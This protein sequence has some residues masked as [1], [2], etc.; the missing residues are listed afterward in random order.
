MAV[1]ETNR[2]LFRIVEVGPAMAK[3]LNQCD[4]LSV[5]N[6]YDLCNAI[7]LLCTESDSIAIEMGKHDSVEGVIN[8]LK[9][10][11]RY[12]NASL[13][14]ESNSGSIILIDTFDVV[15]TILVVLE[16][17]MLLV[18]NAGNCLRAARKDL[19]EAI[20]LIIRINA[21]HN[22]IAEK[23]LAILA[24][25]VR[26][27]H[28]CYLLCELGICDV[29]VTQIT[30]NIKNRTIIELCLM[31]FMNMFKECKDTSSV[32]LLEES[33]VANVLCDLYET[34]LDEKNILEQ[35]C[36]L[37]MYLSSISIFSPRVGRL[38]I[39]TLQIEWNTDEGFSI[40]VCNSISTV[41]KHISSCRILFGELGACNILVTVLRDCMK[42]KRV[43]LLQH[44]LLCI[45]TLTEDCCQNQEKLSH[46]C[47][48]VT[49]AVNY[50]GDVHVT[51]AALFCM[52][53]LCKCGSEMFT[54]NE[55]NLRLFCSNAAP[56]I[57]LH[58]IKMYPKD[59]EVSVL[60]FSV[61]AN[62]CHF[63]NN[64]IRA[65]SLGWL[66]LSISLIHS[67]FLTESVFEAVNSLLCQRNLKN[68]ID[69]GVSETLASVL[70]SNS[71]NFTIL[72]SASEFYCKLCS[73]DN[74][75][76]MQLRTKLS[77][78]HLL[79]FGLRKH[80]STGE[81]QISHV[82]DAIIS[83]TKDSRES[84]AEIE[85]HG[86]CGICATIIDIYSSNPTVLHSN[87]NLIVQLSHVAANKDKLISSG[88]FQFAASVLG[89]T[90]IVMSTISP[91]QTE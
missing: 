5:C 86:M 1:N 43:G 25:C 35:I 79:C 85:V 11:S 83:I 14:N 51:K 33:N 80:S 52:N 81:K 24:I 29:L 16:S 34:Y 28:E 60:C 7:C 82:I 38:L 49:R 26:E 3:V 64:A 4:S 31:T 36:R 27:S 66:Q 88:A 32:R 90:N 47:E 9:L 39:I 91:S 37:I 68:F 44:L 69:L 41:L 56:D 61:I 65:V 62:L 30:R 17:F 40:L 75:C 21:Q 76:V 18:M 73:L 15:K 13:I 53:S 77:V 48:L 57:V 71:E 54:L 67:K 10:I 45:S 59:I 19:F 8:I 12:E 78:H 6:C 74:S 55:I 72:F 46:C 42:I 89:R 58:A 63:D 2:E 50:E 70:K 84:L 87:C 20:I 23:S 22:N